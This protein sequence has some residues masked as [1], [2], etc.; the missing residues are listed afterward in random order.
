MDASVAGQGFCSR[1]QQLLPLGMQKVPGEWPYLPG[2]NDEAV[3]GLLQMVHG[4]YCVY[5]Y[6]P[7]GTGKTHLLQWV[8]L[9]QERWAPY[10]DCG[11]TDPADLEASGM[12]EVPLLCLDNIG[13]WAGLRRAEDILFRLFNA[14]QRS[15]FPW[16]LAGHDM[17]RGMPWILPDWA[18]RLTGC[19]TYGL[20]SPND[21]ERLSILKHIAQRHGQPLPEELGRY[22]L[23]HYSRNLAELAVL[24][25]RF[26]QWLWQH[27]ASP[28]IPR[29]QRFFQEL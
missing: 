14:R 10:M 16:L 18:S 4:G 22:L 11:Q 24:V 26:Q 21:E 15:G 6:G 23:H 20:R 5:L 29:W 3:S 28:S 12:E 27:H 8:A 19:I 7:S 2:I 13:A 25:D 1:G 17:P 9:G